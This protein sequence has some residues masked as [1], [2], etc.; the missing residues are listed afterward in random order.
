MRGLSRLRG[1]TATLLSRRI[2]ETSLISLGML[3]SHSPSTP[4][5]PR[6]EAFIL[7]LQAATRLQTCLC[8]ELFQSQSSRLCA[9][10][11]QTWRA[12]TRQCCVRSILGLL[13][14]LT[15]TSMSMRLRSQSLL[16]VLCS[17]SILPAHEPV[18]RLSSSH[19]ASSQTRR[20]RSFP[21]HLLLSTGP[22]MEG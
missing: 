7:T 16:M 6:A 17:A 11:P 2:A 3:L 18:T 5:F 12:W 15:S 21:G 9:A 14:A 19:A 13:G 22:S 1:S 4:R 8:H 20:H 10:R